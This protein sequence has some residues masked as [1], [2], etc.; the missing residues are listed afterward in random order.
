MYQYSEYSPE[1]VKGISGPNAP[2]AHDVNGNVITDEKGKPLPMMFN[3]GGEG[4]PYRFQGG[5]A[6]Y[7]DVNHDGNINELD[8]VYLGNCNPKMT[9]G[10]GVKFD[11]KRW[12]LNVQFNYRYG[13][14]VLNMA[15]MNAE[16]MIGT[17]NQSYAVNWRWRTEGDT[18]NTLPRALY[19][20]GYNYL[21]SDRFVEDGSFCRLNY[22]QL[23]YTLPSELLKRWNLN[24]ASVSVNA[25]NLFLWTRY[26]GVDPEV[27]Y[28]G[29]GL[30][31]DN[32]QTPRAKS[33]R[34]NL[35]VTF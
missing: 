14:K 32:S 20:K 34:F 3:Y 10:F 27:G 11:Y 23:R 35:N 29:M 5:D 16:N 26:S 24:S 21:G 2:V 7:E 13:S 8:I 18:G 19:N 1:E 22:V 9:G 12:A 30:S 17:N 25:N 28:G 4:T 31:T 33:F 15:K 6:I